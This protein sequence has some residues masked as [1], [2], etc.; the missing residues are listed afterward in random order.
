MGALA[1]AAP[2]L[3]GLVLRRP[4]EPPPAPLALGALFAALAIGVVMTGGATSP[5]LFVAHALG[6]VAGA[7]LR[8]RT[9]G[10]LLPLWLAALLLALYAAGAGPGALVV[11][12]CL[13]AGFS[14]LGRSLLFGAIHAAGLRE[15]ARVDGELL[16]WY[17]D[18]RLFR[19]VGRLPDE[20]EVGGDAR[21]AEHKRIIAS[22]EAVRDGLYRLL[23]L[24]RAALRPDGAFVYLLDPMGEELVLKEQALFVDDQCAP[25]ASARS[26]PLSL[27]LKR[28]R[29][30]RL[31]GEDGS[32]SL[33]RQGP[34][35]AL[36]MVPLLDDRSLIGLLAVDRSDAEPFTERDEE[37]ALTLA[38]EMVQLMRTERVLT[39][40][41]EE[42]REK[43]RV[44]TAARAFGGVVKKD[45]AVR[46]ALKAATQVA[47]LSAVGFFEVLREGPTERLRLL[48]AVG[49]DRERLAG[50]EVRTREGV[51][52]DPEAWIGRAI[53]QGTL[54]PHVPLRQA[55]AARGLVEEGDGLAA[56]FGD[57]RVLPLF[58]QGERVGALVVATGPKDRL[59][60]GHI[61]SLG[62]VAD[63][64]G[65]AFAG[66]GHYEALEKQ[67]TTDGLTGLYNRRTFNERFEEALARAER[68]GNPLS[69]MLT[70]VDHFKSVNDNYGHQVGDDVLV[71][72]ARTLLRCARATDLV[73]RYGGE[74]FCIILEGTDA[75]GA[76]HLAD[77]IRRSI[78]QLRFDTGRGPLEVTSSFGV[79]ELGNHGDDPESLLK[80]ADDALYLAKERGRNRVVMAELRRAPPVV[81]ANA[82]AS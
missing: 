48:G 72:V 56:A 40:L 71:G 4:A 58:A 26:G 80:A 44:F 17:D 63:L 3:G 64:A 6:V 69:L 18:A 52:L 76:A 35:R 62:V 22:T 61:D 53:R 50:S 59:S 32:L 73:A 28:R 36:L 51:P 20:G 57:L 70:D 60:R 46:V 5:V 37:V 82:T 33:H 1:L 10:G 77:R 54:L 24:A 42:R 55:G 74:E 31:T 14:M 39:R 7:V 9:L 27:C 49:D 81:G 21:D 16:R 65:V 34:V 29:P 2:L 45:D 8:P 13:L 43:G 11:Q 67:A 23:C 12:G 15:K 25:R 79:A 47:S 19:L 78:A 38:N 68:A 30:V 66:A 41:D 75:Q